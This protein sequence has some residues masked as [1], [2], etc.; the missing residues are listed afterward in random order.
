MKALTIGVL[1]VLCLLGAVAPAMA[2]ADPLGL[3]S[4]GALL[5][6]IGN[7][8]MLF[9]EVSA[10]VGPVLNLRGIFFDYFGNR[11]G[12]IDIPLTDNDVALV[13]IDD[14]TFPI[15]AGLLAL[16]SSDGGSKLAPLTNPIHA[17]ML[18]IK[19]GQN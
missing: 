3:I 12:T 2:G 5:P 13:R 10:P 4:L 18:W 15:K 9:L 7:G 11:F 16:A 1:V 8:D 6:W 14:L 17:R 19:K